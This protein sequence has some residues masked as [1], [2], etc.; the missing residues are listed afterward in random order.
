MHTPADANC[1]TLSHAAARCRMLTDTFPYGTSAPTTGAAHSSP[2]T[3]KSEP[4]PSEPPHFNWS[5]FPYGASTLQL[6]PPLMEPPHSSRSRFPLRSLRTNNWS[7][8]R[9][10]YRSRYRRL[11]PPTLSPPPAPVRRIPPRAAWDR[12]ICSAVSPPFL[13]GGVL[14]RI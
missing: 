11:P 10:R 4:L 9:R 8:P 12:R 7:R 14:W 2:S 13:L 6:E 3:L 1:H 5:R